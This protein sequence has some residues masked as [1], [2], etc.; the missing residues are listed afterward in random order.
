MEKVARIIRTAID[1]AHFNIGFRGEARNMCYRF[2]I[3]Y[4][5]FKQLAG[6]ATINVRHPFGK[7]QNIID[8]G[9]TDIT[10]QI[11]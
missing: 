5:K 11:F 7:A 10:I 9:V 6:Q 1:A 2:N 3:C 8:D 4:E